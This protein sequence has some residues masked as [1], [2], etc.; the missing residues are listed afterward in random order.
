MTSLYGM[1][2]GN[3][4]VENAALRQNMQQLTHAMNE[5]ATQNANKIHSVCNPCAP[6]GTASCYSPSPWE[7]SVPPS[8]SHAERQGLQQQ[9]AAK[10]KEIETLN[11]DRELLCNLNDRLITEFKC[12]HQSMSEDLRNARCRNRKH[13]ESKIMRLKD[14]MK[15][16]DEMLA[17]F[18]MKFQAMEREMYETHQII[19]RL[20]RESENRRGCGEELKIIKVKS[21]RDRNVQCAPCGDKTF[22]FHLKDD[23]CMVRSR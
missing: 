12:S 15:C 13:L 14:E 21:P 16:K 1:P 5:F 6:C 2:A 20:R 3:L 19:D 22:L 17:Q 9:I 4:A 10:D 11:K 7:T 23:D 8:I 18:R